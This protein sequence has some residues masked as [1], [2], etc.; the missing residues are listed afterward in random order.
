[1]NPG[2]R[3]YSTVSTSKVQDLVTPTKTVRV[4]GSPRAVERIRELGGRLYVRAAR[5]RCCGG[6][7]T[8]LDVSTELPPA[9][10]FDRVEADGFELF[11]DRSLASIA[12]ELHVEERGWIKPRIEAYWNGCA[13][14]L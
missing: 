8:L 4:I 13:Y 14:V 9:G 1:M 12:A 10:T 5:H 2:I 6:G 3:W 7:F 11:L